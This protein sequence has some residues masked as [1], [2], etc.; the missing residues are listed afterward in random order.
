MPI[1]NRDLPA[2]TILVATYKKEQHRALVL[3]SDN[4]KGYELDG[5]TIYRSL[6]AAGSAV[7]GGT[8]CNGWRF[9]SV[10]GGE[11]EAPEGATPAPKREKAPNA[12]GATGKKV[13]QVRKVPNQKG[14]AAG[15]ARWFCS[16]CMVGFVL[17]VDEEPTACP[18]GH[19]REIEDD[20]DPAA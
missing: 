14:V 15:E 19:P 1:T 16:A 18:A 20:L 5:G 17:P 3:E 4:G 13:R 8:A 10:E 9:W 11:P 2:G 12:K 6:S 7:M